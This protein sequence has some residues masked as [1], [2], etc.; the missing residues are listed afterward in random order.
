MFTEFREIVSQENIPIEDGYDTASRYD[1][2]PHYY[3]DGEHK[4]F[5]TVARGEWDE[6]VARYMSQPHKG[7]GNP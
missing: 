2:L 6:G 4:A 5:G 3:A 1:A 7:G